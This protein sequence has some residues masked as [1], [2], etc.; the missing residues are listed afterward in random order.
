MRISIENGKLLDPSNKL[1]QKQDLFIAD[2]KIVSLEKKPDDFNPDLVINAKDKIVLPGLVDLCARLREP[3]FEKKGNFDS[4]LYA[5]NSSGITSI[6]VPPDTTP[7]ID[8]PAVVEFI[9]Q[10]A[11]ETNRANIFPLG[12]LT[13]KLK[14]EQLAEMYLL[15]EAG[16]IGVSNALNAI[17]NTEVLRRAFE[18]AN[19]CD[20]SVFIYAEDEK[21]ANNG[22][23]HEGAISAR[24]GLPAIPETAETIAISRVLLLIEQTDVRVHFCHLSSARAVDLIRTAKKQGIEVTADVSICNLHLTDM[25]IA[26]YDSNCH[27]KPPLRNERDRVG[28]IEGI[29]DETISAVCS[30]HQ[31]HEI[32]AKSAPFSI[33]EPGASTI[34]H[35]LPLMLHL[36]NRN[37]ITLNRAISLITSE[38]A[39]ILG[40]N[41]GFI[42]KNKHADLCIY[43][44]NS[45]ISIDKNNLLSSGKNTPFNGWELQGKV[46]HTLLNGEVVFSID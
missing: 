16:C 32:N 36:V 37:E 5:A 8:T 35:L 44:P 29:R 45:N 14:G 40:I 18:Y 34:E 1:D 15:K 22:V 24:L 31:P 17:E 7:V 23:A 30:D 27:V 6:S 39:K 3:G 10:R 28:L 11:R 26:D 46:T 9:H 41:R 33:T 21:I 20:L 42:E 25:D 43:D 38:P 2:G 13:Q 4:E 12:A 19:S